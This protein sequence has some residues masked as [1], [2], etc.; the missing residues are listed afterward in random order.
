MAAMEPKITKAVRD[1]SACV[2]R[3]RYR[4]A[5]IEYR[6]RILSK[7]IAVSGYHLKCAIEVW[8][9]ETT[10]PKTPR[11]HNRVPLYDEAARQALIVMREAS[12]LL[13]VVSRARA[14]R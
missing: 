9:W 2:V 10:E 13:Q 8:N 12:D 14:R 1:E 3:R 5:T 11:T 6:R 4:T 7:F